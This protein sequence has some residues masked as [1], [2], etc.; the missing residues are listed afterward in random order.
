MLASRPSHG[1]LHSQYDKPWDYH[2]ETKPC[3]FKIKTCPL[4]LGRR[5]KQKENRDCYRW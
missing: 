1:P 3:E 2:V 5:M 4:R